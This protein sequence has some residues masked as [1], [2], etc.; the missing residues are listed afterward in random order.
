MR[1]AIGEIYG[2]P[3]FN[4]KGKAFSEEADVIK[5]KQEPSARKQ[6]LK[7]GLL[8]KARLF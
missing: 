3:S 8:Y 1:L 7:Q 6:N 5:A 2:M 4:K